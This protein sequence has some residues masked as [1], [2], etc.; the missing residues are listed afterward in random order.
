M[1]LKIKCIFLVPLKENHLAD[2]PGQDKQTSKTQPSSLFLSASIKCYGNSFQL[3]YNG[4]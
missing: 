3:Q 4:F 2:K 1:K